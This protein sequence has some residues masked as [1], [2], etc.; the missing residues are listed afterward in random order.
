MEQRRRIRGITLYDVAQR[1]LPR[2]SPVT[3][4]NSSYTQQHSVCP[5]TRTSRSHNS[6]SADRRVYFKHTT[7]ARSQLIPGPHL[8]FGRRPNALARS[9]LARGRCPVFS[10][11]SSFFCILRWKFDTKHLCYLGYRKCEKK[12]SF[13][14]CLFLRIFSFFSLIS[15]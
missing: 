4:R 7:T 13:R 3:L 1:C 15:R 8:I 6:W 5:T 9:T 10:L 2:H 11:F 14:Y 12:V